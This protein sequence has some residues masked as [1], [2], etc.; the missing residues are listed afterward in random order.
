MVVMNVTENVTKF[1]DMEIH[2]IFELS[3]KKEITEWARNNGM[4]AVVNINMKD[5]PFGKSM[6]YVY[7]LA[8]NFSVDITN[9]T[10]L[11]PITLE[12]QSQEDYNLFKLT[13]G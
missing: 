6:N 9:G 1:F 12:F 5:N 4:Y 11:G 8:S 13:W 10:S 3:N 7:T 2:F